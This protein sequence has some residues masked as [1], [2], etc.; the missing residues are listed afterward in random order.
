MNRAEFMKRL[1][2][3]LSDVPP[4]EREAA[5][6][7]YNDYFDDAGVEN[8]SGV[9]ASL[10]TPEEL[11]RS[12]KAGLNDGGDAGEFTESGFSGYAQAHKNEMMNPD[13]TADDYY[14]RTGARRS[15][16]SGASD[17]Q[18]DPGRGPAYGRQKDDFGSGRAKDEKRMS[19]GAIVLIVIALVLT[20][21]VWVGLLGAAFGLVVGV[22]AALF[23]VFVA[24][25]ALGAALMVTS[26]ALLIAGFALLFT[27]P[28][29]GVCVIGASFITFALGLV[30][31]WL[32]IV[33]AGAAIPAV[34]KLIA[35]AGRR[36]FNRGGARA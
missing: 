24:L 35:A 9:I 11:A 32:M 30:F 18:S 12:I 23:G 33:I 5:I 10:G 27:E 36:L 13:M 21:P 7:Y 2:Q 6:R 8:E 31:L 14:R 26:I 22:F 1:S 34:V 3:L 19:G 4:A 29:P 25:F 16:V 17:A 28:I 20:F 15:Y